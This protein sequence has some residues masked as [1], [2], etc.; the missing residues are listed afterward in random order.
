MQSR[1]ICSVFNVVHWIR[2]CGQLHN[3]VMEQAGSYAQHEAGAKTTEK[4]S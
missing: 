1:E 2:K 3:I 4:E